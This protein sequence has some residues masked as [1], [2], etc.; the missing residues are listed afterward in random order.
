MITLT[1]VLCLIVGFIILLKTPPH[2]FEGGGQFPGMQKKQ[3]NAPVYAQSENTLRF[4]QFCKKECRYRLMCMRKGAARE[5]G[6]CYEYQ[7][8]SNALW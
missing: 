2:G 6:S 7:L 3:D 1:L 4:E 8:S 5:E